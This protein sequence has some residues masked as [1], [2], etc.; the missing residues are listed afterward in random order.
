M[1]RQLSSSLEIDLLLFSLCYMQRNQFRGLPFEPSSGCFVSAI[2][3]SS[4]EGFVKNCGSLSFNEFTT[5]APVAS[6]PSA[7]FGEYLADLSKTLTEGTKIDLNR[8][9]FA[10]LNERN[11]TGSFVLLC[12]IEKDDSVDSLRV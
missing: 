12:H 8:N 2:G 11:K 9:I 5:K 3:H 10:V 1:R 4:Q 6:I 7:Y